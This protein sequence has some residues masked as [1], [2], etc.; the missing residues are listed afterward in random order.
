M[1]DL[2]VLI[3][4]NIFCVQFMDQLVKEPLLVFN[5][6]SHCLS[7]SIHQ[8]L[9]VNCVCVRV[10]DLCVSVTGRQYCVCV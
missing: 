9:S 6:L 8:T 7:L 10:C 4:Y 1:E 3:I 5:N 2:F